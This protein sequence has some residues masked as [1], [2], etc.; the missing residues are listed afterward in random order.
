MGIILISFHRH[1]ARY[2]AG[3]HIQPNDSNNP[4]GEWTYPPTDTFIDAAGLRPI[5][6]SIRRRRESIL[7]FASE[8]YMNTGN[9]WHPFLY[10]VPAW[11]VP[12]LFPYR[13]LTLV[14]VCTHDTVHTYSTV[15]SQCNVYRIVPYRT[16]YRH[17]RAPKSSPVIVTSGGLRSALNHP[18]RV[19]ESILVLIPSHFARLSL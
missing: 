5:Q 6:E 9:V 19:H 10:L 8:R 1:C 17:K 4:Q 14:Y 3:Q 2:S 11:M 7:H 12:T 16:A 18:S 13:I 15:I